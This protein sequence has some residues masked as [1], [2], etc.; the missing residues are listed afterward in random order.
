MIGN[1][2]MRRSCHNSSVT[3]QVDCLSALLRVKNG[4][5][6]TGGQVLNTSI[7]NQIMKVRN[8]YLIGLNVDYIRL[9]CPKRQMY[10]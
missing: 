6:G 1:T 4:L 9:C 3:G 7:L 10:A 5:Y 8:S 2:Q